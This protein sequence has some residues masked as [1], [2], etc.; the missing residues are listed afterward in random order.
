MGDM[1]GEANLWGSGGIPP[2]PPPP[3]GE[4]LLILMGEIKK[5]RDL[6]LLTLFL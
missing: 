1:G 4:T 2:I 3:L 5:Q 6:E